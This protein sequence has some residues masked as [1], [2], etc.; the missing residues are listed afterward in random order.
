MAAESAL[1]GRMWKVLRPII[2]CREKRG[3]GI[4]GSTLQHCPAG[5]RGR[6]WVCAP[7]SRAACAASSFANTH[8]RTVRPVPC[9]SVA[10][11]RTICTGAAPKGG[12]QP[13]GR[14]SAR[15]PRSAQRP[16][17]SRTP[18]PACELCTLATDSTRSLPT[19]AARSRQGIAQPHVQCQPRRRTG[20]AG[21]GARQRGVASAH[22]VASPRVD[23]QPQM[24]LHRLVKPGFS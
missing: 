17:M 12:A 7:A 5:Q 19:P 8:T 1:K 18:Q 22:L 15:V 2:S 9:G 20:S 11:P 14:R 4:K 6:S 21:D 23:S 13:P 24:Q 10:A 16:G 3:R